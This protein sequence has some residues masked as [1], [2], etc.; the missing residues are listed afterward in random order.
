MSWARSSLQMRHCYIKNK[1]NWIWN[2]G[3]THKIQW[4]S[5]II[6]TSRSNTSSYGVSLRMKFAV[7]AYMRLLLFG[8]V[9]ASSVISPLMILMSVLHYPLLFHCKLLHCLLLL[10]LCTEVTCDSLTSASIHV[11]PHSTKTETVLCT[12]F[13]WLCNHRFMQV[14]TSRPP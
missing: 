1:N 2:A 12:V 11:H 9:I 7:T 10:K 3:N 4:H 13:F 5:V 8:T 6:S 14:T